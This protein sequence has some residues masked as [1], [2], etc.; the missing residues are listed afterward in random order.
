VSKIAEYFPHDLQLLP[1]NQLAPV[2][3]H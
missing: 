1:G 2:D 3:F